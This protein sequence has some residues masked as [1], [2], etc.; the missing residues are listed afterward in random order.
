MP[1]TVNKLESSL[2][3]YPEKHQK[4][5][6]ADTVDKFPRGTDPDW[7]EI[8]TKI[9][10]WLKKGIDAPTAMQ[11]ADGWH[12][13]FDAVNDNAIFVVEGQGG[14]IHIDRVIRLANLPKNKK[15]RGVDL[16]DPQWKAKVTAP[17]PPA[18]PDPAA[19]PQ[20]PPSDP[21]TALMGPD[22]N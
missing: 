7:V 2:E 14:S 16:D 21:A 19:K 3:A 6:F 13:K 18:K 10:L 17:K 22:E 8:L 5:L 12:K 20:T 9:K 15:P 1:S 11:S 4:R